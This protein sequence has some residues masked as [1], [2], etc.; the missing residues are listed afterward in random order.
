MC[1]AGGAIAE[2]LDRSPEGEPLGV[3]FDTCHARAAGYDPRT[4]AGQDRTWD[5]FDRENRDTAALRA[6]SQRLQEATGCRVDCHAHIGEGTIG[7]GGFVRHVKG[8]GT[9]GAP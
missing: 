4:A 1:C 3:G 5:E 7:M 9:E 2:M 6:A 8:L